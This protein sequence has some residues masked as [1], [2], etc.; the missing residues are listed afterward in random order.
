MQSLQVL[1]LQENPITFPPKEVIQ[2]PDDMAK[3]TGAAE[4]VM[5]IRIKDF[6][7]LHAS[8]GQIEGDTSRHKSSEGSAN[9]PRFPS[10]RAVSG[11]FPVKINDATTPAF[12]PSSS[13]AFP[14]PPVPTRSHFRRLSQQS[15]TVPQQGGAPSDNTRERPHKSPE[16]P[17]RFDLAADYIKRRRGVVIHDLDNRLTPEKAHHGPAQQEIPPAVNAAA[18]QEESPRHPIRVENNAV[19]DESRAGGDWISPFLDS[20]RKGKEGYRQSEQLQNRNR[21]LGSNRQGSG[22]VN[23]P[24]PIDTASEALPPATD[25]GYASLPTQDYKGAIHIGVKENQQHHYID[26]HGNDGGLQIYEHQSATRDSIYTIGPDIPPFRKDA[27]I[28]SLAE[29]I[30]DKAFT[31]APDEK[32]LERICKA[33]P[34]LLKTFAIKVG[35]SDSVSIYRDVMV[36]VRRYRRLVATSAPALVLGR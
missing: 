3:G 4:V 5:T 11:R 26:L 34:Q 9:V 23:E 2:H 31:E 12:L 14:P 13:N 32:T 29:D 30:R 35:S 22:F 7:R 1:M 20:S 24:R 19:I 27:Y 8:T 21:N 36:F 10:K 18:S 28:S 15:S 33:L 16:I 6:L 17:L 25:S